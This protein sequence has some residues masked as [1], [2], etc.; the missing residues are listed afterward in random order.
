MGWSQDLDW[1]EVMSWYSVGGAVYAVTGATLQEPGSIDAYLLSPPLRASAIA[2]DSAQSESWDLGD[3]W[4]WWHWDPRGLSIGERSVWDPR[5][6]R[7]LHIRVMQRSERF[8]GT[9]GTQ[10]HFAV[11]VGSIS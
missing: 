2:R 6:E 11:L 3:D 8:S 10:A 4:P 9:S 5:I 7:S 1:I